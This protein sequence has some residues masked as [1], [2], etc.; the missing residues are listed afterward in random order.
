MHH[1]A[2]RGV[3][4]IFVGIQ[5]HQK[6]YLVYVPC[7]RKIISSYDVVFDEI[8]SSTLVHKSQP[9]AE[10]MVMRPSLSRTSYATCSRDQTGNIITFAQFEERNLLSEAQD[11]LSKTLD[12]TES[13]NKSDE[14]STMPQLISEEEMGVISSGGEYD[15]EPMS[16]DMLE[17]IFDG[18]QSH[19]SENSR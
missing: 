14:D 15:A 5:Q 19:P 3:C 10:A 16:T 17:N 2:Q 1:Q 11:L 13:G 9:Y 8:C 6:G 12:N 4:G 7:T 18:S